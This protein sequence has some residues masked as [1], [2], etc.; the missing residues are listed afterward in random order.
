[1]KTFQRIVLVAV[2]AALAFG[3]GIITGKKEA[4]QVAMSFFND[5]IENGG[6]GSPDFYSEKF[7]EA[8]DPEKWDA[9]QALVQKAMGNLTGYH[10][11]GWQSK[12]L[13]MV[14]GD[15]PSGTY[16]SM[17]FSTTYE[18]GSGTETLTLYCPASG[19]PFTILGHNFNS[20]A[21]REAIDR[22]IFKAAS[23]EV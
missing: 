21:I 22:G 11:E 8:T 23:D 5:R 1:M 16:V 6:T 20:A 4:E 14:S 18:K 17:H 12:Q 19:G 3:C 13:T 10:L 15:T 2:V 9:I 7:W